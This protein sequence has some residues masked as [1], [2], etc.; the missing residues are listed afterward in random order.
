M[1]LCLEPSCGRPATNKRLGLCR[2]CYGYRWSIERENAPNAPKC[3]VQNCGS[4]ARVKGMCLIHYKR[5]KR[6]SGDPLSAPG[7]G[8]PGKR[9][10]IRSLKGEYITNS[11]YKRRRNLK[12]NWVDEHRIIMEQELGRPLLPGE[13][14]HHINGD[15]LDNRIENLE[16]WLTRQPIGARVSDIVEWAR[17]IIALYD[18]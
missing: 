18:S 8:S 5:A 4:V 13:N 10:G 9:R 2:R 3:I 16:L 15:K 12:G 1:N 17:K 11:G 7:R 6:N 14:V